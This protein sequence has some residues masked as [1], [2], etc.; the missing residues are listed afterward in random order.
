MPAI[1]D[2]ELIGEIA[3]IKQSRDKSDQRLNRVLSRLNNVLPH[4]KRERMLAKFASELGLTIQKGESKR[5]DTGTAIEAR[6]GDHIH[7]RIAR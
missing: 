7:M 2:A 5:N 4:D 6:V 3:A 1:T